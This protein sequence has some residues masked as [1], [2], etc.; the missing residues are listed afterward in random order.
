MGSSLTESELLR[1]M[2]DGDEA[3]FGQLFACHQRAVYGFALQMTGSPSLAEESVQEVFMVLIRQ[4]DRFDPTR[5]SLR[6]FLY[7]VARNIVRR[8]LERRGTISD[9]EAEIVDASPTPHSLL[10]T[11][12]RVDSIRTAVLSLPERYREVVVLCD[13]QELSYDQ[14]AATLGC[15]KGTVR[16]RLHRGRSLLRKKLRPQLETGHALGNAH[17]AEG[18]L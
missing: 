2:K 14:T 15:S 7:G 10:A 18:V 13:L 1:R 5:G 3:A 17:P 16:S 4:P 6:A 8:L 11:S 9:V 12:E